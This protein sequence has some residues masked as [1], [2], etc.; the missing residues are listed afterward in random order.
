MCECK[1][2]EKE[3]VPK[4]RP[5]RQDKLLEGRTLSCGCL[6]LKQETRGKHKTNRFDIESK[7]YGV[8]YTYDREMFFFDKEDFNKIIEV[9]SSWNINDGG[10]LAAR[11]NREDSDRY[12]NGRKKLVYLKDIVI[13]KNENEIVKYRNPKDKND[14]RKSNLI[15]IKKH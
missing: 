12:S 6:K 10:Y 8:G 2:Q 5:I 3:R 14:N 4:Q 9:S 15:K 11:D 13:N 1:C 7:E